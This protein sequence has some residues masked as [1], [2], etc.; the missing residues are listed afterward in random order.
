[1]D[2]WP[3]GLVGV[4]GR[5]GAVGEVDKRGHMRRVSVVP[6]PYTKPHPPVFL[7]SSSPETI[8]YSG[9]KGFVPVYVTS[10]ARAKQAGH[11]YVQAAGEAGREY[12]LGQPEIFKN[13]YAA[14]GRRRLRDPNNIVRSMIDTGLYSFGTADEVKDQLVAQWRKMPAEYIVLIFHY[15]QMPKERVIYNLEKFMTDVKPALDELGPR[16]TRGR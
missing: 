11:L 16:R 3:F 15:A 9:R 1:M 10:L 5:L 7:A 14:M 12:A 6:A 13:F 2:D 8:E 4:T